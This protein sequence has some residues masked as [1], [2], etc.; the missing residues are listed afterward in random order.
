M[1]FHELATNAAKYGALS[2]SSGHIQVD[3][4]VV[5]DTAPRRLM[6]CWRETGG[7]TVSEP[8]RKGFGSRLI[9]GLAHETSGRV[10]MDYPPTGLICKFDIPLFAEE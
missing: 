7:P 3:W 8:S 10:E 1:A 9:R 6:V 4:S 5:E 2:N